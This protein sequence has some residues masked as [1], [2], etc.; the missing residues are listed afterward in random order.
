MTHL[1]TIS[2]A[3]EYAIDRHLVRYDPQ[4]PR[5]VGL[6]DGWCDTDYLRTFTIRQVR[7]CVCLIQD[8]VQ[9]MEMFLAVTPS[10]VER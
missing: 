10:H 5:T 1:Q 8:D 9:M 6:L 4:V 3:V 2:S 7:L